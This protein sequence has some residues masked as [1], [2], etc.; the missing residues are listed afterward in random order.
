MASPVVLHITRPYANAEEY[1]AAEAWSVDARAMLLIDQPY[2]EP[3]TAIV[4]DVTLGDG[5]R[6]IKAEA[7]VSRS[8]Q[9][10]GDRPGGLRVRFKRYGAPT[11]AFIDR[12]MELVATGKSVPPA[13]PLV[14]SDPSATSAALPELSAEIVAATLPGP[15][16]AP[17]PAPASANFH[18]VPVFA[19]TPPDV[20]ASLPGLRAR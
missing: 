20:P 14:A 7:K 17:A 15:D 11:K 19:S 1:L 16:L 3:D 2:L 8:V 5:S 9:A 10:D 18:P 6:P 12:A 4:F 13:P